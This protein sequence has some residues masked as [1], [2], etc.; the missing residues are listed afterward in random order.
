MTEAGERPSCGCTGST[1]TPPTPPTATRPQF[2]DEAVELAG[3]RGVVS[4]LPQGDFPW[5]T[6]PS[7]AE[8]DVAAIRAEVARHR[9]AV[10]R[11]AA[12]SDV[13]GKRRSLRLA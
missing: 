7:A 2:L 1:P 4:I 10:D 12:R 6:D 13:D 9:S 8:P 3:T 5:S 11:L